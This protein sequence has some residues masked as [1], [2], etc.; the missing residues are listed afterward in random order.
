MCSNNF[1]NDKTLYT[2]Y[3]YPKQ[4]IAR[5]SISNFKTMSNKYNKV[6]P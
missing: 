2:I 5:F 3:I 4:L 1:R 6:R